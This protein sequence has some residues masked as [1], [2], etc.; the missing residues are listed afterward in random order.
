MMQ[1]TDLYRQGYCRLYCLKCKETTLHRPI[2]IER[3]NKETGLVYQSEWRCQCIKCNSIHLIKAN[4]MSLSRR[5]RKAAQT[6]N[7]H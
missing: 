7:V 2:K 1:L 4:A 6:L 3:T 5:K